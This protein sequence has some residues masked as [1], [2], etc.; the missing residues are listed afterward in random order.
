MAVYNEKNKKKW[1]KDGRHWY[2]IVHYTDAK[3]RKRERY[4][5]MFIDRKTAERE[6]LKFKTKVSNPLLVKFNVVADEY[7]DYLSKS[8][9]SSTVYTYLTAYSKNI[10][11][12]FESFYINDIN[13][14]TINDWKEQVEKNG[15]KTNYLNKLLDILRGIFEF[16]IKN[17]D[18]DSNPAY[19]SG[20]FE[21]AK[22]EVIDDKEKIRYITYD[23]FNKFISVIDDT[24]WK[25]FFMFL[26]YTGMRIGEVQALNWNDIDF[27]TNQINVN[28]TL[29]TKVMDIEYKITSTKNYLNRKVEMNKTLIEQ[30]KLYKNEC[31]KY[32]DFNDN[33]FVFGCSRFLPSTTINRYKDYYFKL[34]GVKRITIHEFRHSHVSLLINEY[35]KVSKEKNMKIDTAK[36]FL[37]MSS[38]MGH[39]VEVM[40]R[41]YMHLFPSVQ[42]EV[43]DL[44]NN[45]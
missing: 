41:T 35:V 40:H 34:S 45:L 28:K 6:E 26:Y 23:E 9:K 29:N 44:L 43:V 18:L 19:I 36:F 1:T 33:W 12:Y 38:R 5:K 15:F 2:Y 37:M 27:N 32:A 30:M 7:F 3:G 16:G 31:M 11:P 42:D 10:K 4:S 13:V 17:Y 21:K 25:T 39:S 8:K 14:H 22:E 24:T 20:R